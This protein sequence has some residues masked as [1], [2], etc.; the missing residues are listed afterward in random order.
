M[1]QCRH[2]E[3][4]EAE[5]HYCDEE[6]LITTYLVGKPAAHHAWKHDTSEVLE[7][8]AKG[9][10]GGASLAMREAD[11]I[12]RIGCE[13]KSV[14]NLFDKDTSGDEG[15]ALCL[16]ETEPDIDNVRQCDA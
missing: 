15:Q 4:D 1:E 3:R 11:K 16:R 6:G 8:C 12:E 7:G 5:A 14:A 10:D 2:S 13:A 9:E